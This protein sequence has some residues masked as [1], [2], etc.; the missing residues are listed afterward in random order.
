[1]SYGCYDSSTDTWVFTCAGCGQEFQASDFT[2]PLDGL[3]C[4]SAECDT[5]DLIALGAKQN[6]PDS[7]LSRGT[8]VK[9]PSPKCCSKTG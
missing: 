6:V 1:M 2:S 3:D 4:C 5:I 8:Q 7:G 9:Q